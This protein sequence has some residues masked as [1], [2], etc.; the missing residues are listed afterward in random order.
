[1][2]SSDPVRALAEAVSELTLTAKVLHPRVP[3]NPAS[4]DELLARAARVLGT[5][6]GS[7]AD[8]RSNA[9]GTA[10]LLRQFAPDLLVL[11]MRLDS[12]V[13]TVRA[14]LGSSCVLEP[15]LKAAWGRVKDTVRE[16]HPTAHANARIVVGAI[17]RVLDEMMQV[18]NAILAG[19][20]AVHRTLK[21]LLQI[22]S[23]HQVAAE[24]GPLAV[25]RVLLADP[26][27][28]WSARGLADSAEIEEAYRRKPNEKSVRRWLD[29]LAATDLARCDDRTG[30]WSLG[31]AAYA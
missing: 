10:G 27:R 18:L 16:M 2:T 15:D 29:Q 21:G 31:D 4:S 11:V 24:G 19:R 22:K 7:V 12:L 6:P 14:A 13:L 26:D 23:E 28:V 17:Q 20:P 5:D 9:E 8:A 25:L 3:L 1:M 30:T